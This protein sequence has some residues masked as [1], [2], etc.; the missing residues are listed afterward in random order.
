[1]AARNLLHKSK[2]TAFRTY[3]ESKGWTI[4]PNK[5]FYDI[6]RARHPQYT[7]PLIVY[8]RADAKEHYTIEGRMIHIVRAWLQDRV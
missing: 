4:E 8:E 7:H 5:G 2:L 1:M 6:L 3:L